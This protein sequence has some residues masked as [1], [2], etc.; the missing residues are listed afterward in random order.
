MRYRRAVRVL[1][2]EP[3]EA[4]ALIQFLWERRFLGVREAASSIEV[5]APVGLLPYATRYRLRR[6]LREW[7]VGHPGAEASLLD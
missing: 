1:I 2:S 4:D 3:A 6:S 7:N 5:A